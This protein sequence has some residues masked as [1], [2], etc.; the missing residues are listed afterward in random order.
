MIPQNIQH[1]IAPQFTAPASQGQTL[2][3]D[4][5]RGKTL[6][7]YFYPK[8]M[9]PGCTTQVCD[10]TRHYEDFVK[11]QCEILGVSRDTPQRHDAFIEKHNVPFSLVS[12][13]GDATIC[14]AYGVWQKK[15]FLGKTYHG[16]VRSTFIIDKKGYVQWVWSP[17]KAKGHA[18][19]VLQRLDG[20]N[21]SDNDYNA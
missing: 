17:V 5:Y 6:I 16:I 11:L 18:E 21:N 15:S 4:H 19:L 9:T 2:N 3:L 7:L 10:F 12:D 14:K 8:D 1:K 13:D 20:K